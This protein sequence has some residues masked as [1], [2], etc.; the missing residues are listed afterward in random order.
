M[1]NWVRFTDH[2]DQKDVL[3][4]LNLVARVWEGKTPNV[5]IFDYDE[6]GMIPIV[7]NFSKI[8][9][10]YFDHFDE[11]VKKKLAPKKKETSYKSNVVSLVPSLKVQKD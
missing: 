3:I 5:T 2:R 10:N 1:S 6:Y 9:T 4:D 11:R 7:G 8:L